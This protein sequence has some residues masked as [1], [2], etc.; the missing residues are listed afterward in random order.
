MAMNFLSV[1]LTCIEQPAAALGVRAA[2]MAIERIERLQSP[3]RTLQRRSRLL[4]GRSCA[5]SL[6]KP[7]EKVAV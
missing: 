5:P 2:E 4:V 1:P 3:A 6:A 7:R